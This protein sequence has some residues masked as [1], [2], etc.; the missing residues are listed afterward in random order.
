[1]QT[2][3]RLSQNKRLDQARSLI[4]NKVKKF[5]I[6]NNKNIHTALANDQRAKCLVERLT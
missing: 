1:M 5:V 4:G 2:H 3:P 6:I